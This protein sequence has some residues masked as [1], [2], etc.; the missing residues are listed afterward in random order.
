LISHTGRYKLFPVV[1]TPIA[2]TGVLLIS[3]L[4]RSSSGLAIILST[5]VFG[6][7]MGLTVQTFVVALQNA[8]DRADLGVATAANQF[9]RSIGGTLAVAAFGTLLVSRLGVELAHRSIRNLNPQELLR[10]PAVAHR[11]PPTVV[12]GVHSSLAHALEWVFLGTLPLM[13]VAV[14]AALLLRE[15]PLRTDS[16]VAAAPAVDPPVRAGR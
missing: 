13:A 1:G 6:V 15:A 5:T 11:F 8:V 9:F 10:S 3:Q 14:G 7:G 12:A 16:P 4:S 2:F